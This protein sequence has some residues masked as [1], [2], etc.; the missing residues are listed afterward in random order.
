[1]SV[2]LQDQPAPGVRRLLINRPDKRNAIDHDVRQAFMAALRDINGDRS[3]RALVLGGV[4][5]TFSAGGDIASMSDLAEEQARQ[6]MQHIHELCRLVIEVPVPVVS[7]AEG[8]CAGAG[9]GLALLG[10]VIVA[11]QGSRFLFPFMKLGLVPDWG[12]LRTLPAR[13]GKA[14]ALQI[15]TGGRAIPG[16]EAVRIGLADAYVG[17]ADVMAAVISRA[18]AMS[19]LPG[20]AFA[21][22]K[23]RLNRPSESFGEELRREEDDQAAL[24][25]GPDFREGYSAFREKRDPDFINR[26]AS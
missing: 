20:G 1:M 13:I 10:D 26:V 7:A 18:V 22:L 17:E 25:T 21:A 11:G 19:R 4:G 12:S 8:Y 5:G 23:S 16:E 9:A 6:R 3:C 14:A 2:L 15:L 24:L